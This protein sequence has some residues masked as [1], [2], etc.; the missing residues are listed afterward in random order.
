MKIY[1]NGNNWI[2]EDQLNEELVKKITTITDAIQRTP[3][4]FGTPITVIDEN[5]NN[6]PKLKKSYS[7]QRKNAEQYWLIKKDKDNDF[8]FQNKN[9]ENIKKEYKVNILNRLKKSNLLRQNLKSLDIDIKNC[10][11]VVGKENS[12]HTPHFHNYGLVS[13]IS[14][15]LYLNVPE[16][17]IENLPENN[18][19]LIMNSGPNNEFYNSNPKIISINPE[20]GKLLIF[21]DWII[22]GTHPQ[23][24]GI[25]QTFNID[26]YFTF[27]GDNKKILNNNLNYA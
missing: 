6:F 1:Q 16:S 12:F 9:F 3:S 4:Y 20:V 2:I 19:F 11:T 8:Y 21:P 7:S 25:R 27:D 14:T 18:L 15:L 24:K 22:H 13:G 17:N 5:L 26:Y 23:T 10:W